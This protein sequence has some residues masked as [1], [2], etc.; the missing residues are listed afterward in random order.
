MQL[1]LT[2]NQSELENWKAGGMNEFIE[3]F[4]EISIQNRVYISVPKVI[5]PMSF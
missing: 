5:G 2:S 1:G 4:T 3:R